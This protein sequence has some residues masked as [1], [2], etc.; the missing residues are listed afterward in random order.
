MPPAQETLKNLL[1]GRRGAFFFDKRQYIRPHKPKQKRN[2][3]PP[4]FCGRCIRLQGC[5]KT[6]KA[7][8]KH[9]Q[10]HCAVATSFAIVNETASTLSTAPKKA[11]SPALGVIRR[12]EKPD[13]SAFRFSLIIQ[14]TAFRTGIQ[15]KKVEFRG[16][17]WNLVEFSGI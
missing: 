10:T 9:P 14:F 2:P 4:N 17:K 12:S 3:Q 8:P 11:R 1:P 7:A 5:G 13:R 16:K 15:W 6:R